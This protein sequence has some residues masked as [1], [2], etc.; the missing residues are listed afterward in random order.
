MLV[1]LLGSIAI[2]YRS[3]GNLLDTR[4]WSL[5]LMVQAI[6]YGAAVLMALISALPGLRSGWVGTSNRGNVSPK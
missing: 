2:L 6:A 3:D 5:A 1:L 4:V